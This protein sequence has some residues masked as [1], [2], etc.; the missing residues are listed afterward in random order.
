MATARVGG[1]TEDGVPCF[2]NQHRS[3]DDWAQAL[4]FHNCYNLKIQHLNLL[5]NAKGHLALDACSDATVSNVFISAPGNSPNTDDIDIV[6]SSH[7]EILDNTIKSGD[8]CVVI[9]GGSSFINIGHV[10]YGPGHGIRYSLWEKCEKPSENGAHEAVEEVHVSNCNII[11]STM[12]GLR[13]KTWQ[14]GADILFGQNIGCKSLLVFLGS[15]L[16]IMG[17]IQASVYY[18]GA[19][20]SELC[21]LTDLQIL[22]LSHNHLLGTIPRCF[23]NFSILVTQQIKYYGIFGEKLKLVMKGVELEYT[24]TLGLVRS[25]DLSS[26]NLS[27]EIPTEVTSLQGLSSLNLSNNYLI[28]K[29]PGTL[30]NM[31]SLESLDFL[32]NQISSVIPHNLSS[33]TFLSYLNLSYNNLSREIPLSTQLQSLSEFSYIGNLELC[34][35]PLKKVVPKKKMVTVWQKTVK[36]LGYIGFM[37]ACH[38]D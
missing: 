31:S 28:G 10:Q 2:N 18:S 23:N 4:T 15:F 34:G 38:L 11:T 30:G 24:N 37:L 16:T 25:I 36:S 17:A 9:N 19:I 13:I 22:D 7:I 6:S 5:N 21:N 12:Y 14:I 27:G 8:D 26:N 1:A 32:V 35:P 33:L 20:L 3:D 29:I